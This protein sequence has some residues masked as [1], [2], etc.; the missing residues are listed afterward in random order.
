LINADFFVNQRGTTSSTTS[1][2]FLVDR[3]RIL[4]GA[5]A[6]SVTGSVEQ[7]TLGS[8]PVAG[9]E[10]KQYCRIVTTG[11]AASTDR[12]L[13][14]YPGIEDVRTFAGQTVTLSFW[15]KAST[16]TPI[17][18]TEFVQI[19]GSGGSPTADITGIGATKT[20][21]STSW[22]R[23]SITVTIPSIAGKTIGTNPNTSGLAIVIWVSAGS[24]FN[25]RTD[26]LGVQDNTF[27]IWGVQ[28]EAGS[29]ATAFTTASGGS[30]QSELAMCHRYYCELGNNLSG[31]SDNSTTTCQF[32]A[33]YPVE[34][35]VSPSVSV[36]SGRSCRIRHFAADFTNASPGLIAP[37]IRQ[38]AMWTL[39][40]GFTG[41]TANGVA[42]SRNNSATARFIAASAEY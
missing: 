39:V 40:N 21:I 33:P 31:S 16:G 3:F 30:T 14:Q 6:G 25:S 26:S 34:M 27:D 11:Q 29:V 20:T 10:A 36:I 2:T 19:F 35:R 4:L 1:A 42:N 5:A 28:L 17:I 18:A 12:A 9:Y 8:A 15:A 38:D 24:N 22:T 7:F 41:L 32:V 37:A 23:Y 13:L